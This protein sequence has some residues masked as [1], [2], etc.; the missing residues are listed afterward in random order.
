MLESQTPESLRAEIKE[1]PHWRVVIRPGVHVE[2][3]ID[4]LSECWRLIESSRVSLRGWDYPHVDHQHRQN[5]KDWIES[6]DDYRSHRE[7][8]RLYQSGQFLHL[9]SFTEDRYRDKAEEKAK[10]D[11]L[12]LNDFSLS[13]YLSAISALW[14]ITEI[15]EFAARLAQKADFGDSASVAIQMVRVKDR[16]LFMSDPGR[17]FSRPYVAKE[18]ILSKEWSLQTEQLLSE[19]PELALNAAE[20]FFERFGWMALPRQVMADD[21]RKLLERKF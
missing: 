6:W 21:Q 17:D 11:V 10:S 8:W 3:R 18:S 4:T 9:F 13:G 7:Y 20:W 15:F 1:A 5:G 14:T 19:S 2:E 16:A 12:A